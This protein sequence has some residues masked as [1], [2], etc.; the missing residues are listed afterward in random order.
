VTS[1][2]GARKIFW[3]FVL[4][5]NVKIFQITFC[6]IV[7]KGKKY[8][9]YSGSEAI[10]KGALKAGA[11]FLTGYPITPSSEIMHLWSKLLMKDENLKF[12]Q[13]EDEIA[14]I[15]VAIGASLA[16]RKAFTATSGPGFSLMQEGL[17]SA[18]SMQVPLVVVNSQRQGPATG[19]PTI[20]SQGDVLQTQHGT[21]GDYMSIVFCPNSIKE[22]YLLTIDAFNATQECKSPV[23]LLSEAYMTNMHEEEDLDSLEVQ[24]QGSK[25]V[26]LTKD[27]TARHFTGLTQNQNGVETFKAET[28][29][30][31]IGERRNLILET[32]E[33]YVFFET[34][35]KQNSKT[36]LISYGITSRIVDEI[37]EESESFSHFRPKRLFPVLE[38]E[39]KDFA[40]DFEE[41]VVIEMNEGQY[42]SKVQEVLLRQV[43]KVRVIGAEPSKEDILEK[44]LKKDGN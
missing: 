16:G 21:H 11:T 19:M 36:L 39:L 32:A 2:I 30:A 22:L 8:K 14:S 24:I 34:K 44:I 26:P 7:D 27:S 20:A 40:K 12:M 9:S 3:S 35:R 28:Y 38:K 13:M 29:E 17:G 4:K 15:H 6:I 43:K 10:V 42:A 25:L 41:I 18:F 33:K 31:W 37:V 23:I 5:C 1:S